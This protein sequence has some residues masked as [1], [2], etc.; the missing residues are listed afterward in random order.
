MSKRYRQLDKIVFKGLSVDDDL[1]ALDDQLNEEYYEHGLK[2]ARGTDESYEYSSERKGTA[3]DRKPYER[4]P[5][6]DLQ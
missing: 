5:R 6:Q 3:K 2:M 4:R 1:E